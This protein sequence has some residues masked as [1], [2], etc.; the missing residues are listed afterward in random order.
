MACAEIK[1]LCEDKEKL[2]NQLETQ[3][4]VIAVLQKEKEI[5]E[6]EANAYRQKLIESEINFSKLKSKYEDENII[7]VE[8]E[9]DE[10]N[11]NEN[12]IDPSPEPS[13]P[14]QD[15][16]NLQTIPISRNRSSRTKRIVNADGDGASK[17]KP[18]QRRKSNKKKFYC[19]ICNSVWSTSAKLERHQETHKVVQQCREIG[20]TFPTKYLTTMRTHYN[21]KHPGV[22]FPWGEWAHVQ[23]DD[24]EQ[25]YH[26]EQGC[27]RLV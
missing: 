7:Y 24:Q 20:C 9:S 13:N 10:N 2:K 3:S 19:E 16:A 4:N 15:L 11:E 21:K 12:A 6:K 22:R 5:F 17:P 27:S 8:S 18:K 1:K 25:Q 26:Q 14:S 23:Q